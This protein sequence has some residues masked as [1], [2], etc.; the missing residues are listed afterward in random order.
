MTERD[1]WIVQ[2]AARLRRGDIDAEGIVWSELKGRRLG[3]F[4]FRRQHVIGRFIVDFYC[5]E[6]EVAVEIDGP[7]HREAADARRD[8]LLAAVGVTVVRFDNDDIYHHLGDCL[9]ILVRRLRAPP[10]YRRRGGRTRRPRVSTLEQGS[11][12]PL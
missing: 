7:T 4:K 6:K 12:P 2:R 5:A 1:P 9:D 8:R 10:S 3:G 11:S